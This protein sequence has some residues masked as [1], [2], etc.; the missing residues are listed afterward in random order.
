MLSK[1]ELGYLGQANEELY[2]LLSGGEIKINETGDEILITSDVVRDGVIR[3]RVMV[4][5]CRVNGSVFGW[6]CSHDDDARF[7]YGSRSLHPM[8]WAFVKR[9]LELQ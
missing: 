7:W 8:T 5:M 1:N 2:D 6:V 9:V 3:S 4:E